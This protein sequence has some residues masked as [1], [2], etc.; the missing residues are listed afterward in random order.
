MT[1]ETSPPTPYYA[2]AAATRPTSVTVLASIGIVLGALGVLCKPAG[3]MINLMVKMPQPNP[4]MD[5]FRNDPAIRA[6][7]IGNAAT[8]TLLSAL[9]LLSSL[10]SLALKPWARMGMLAYGSLAV[11]MTIIGQLVGLFLIGP[12]LESAMRQSGVQ[13]PAG[14]AWM[15]GG[16]G[17][18]LG[19]VIGLWYPALIFIY[20]TRRATR[21]AFDQGLSGTGI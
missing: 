8:G 16:V 3:A 21:E 18:A 12:Q 11:L 5:T 4:I 15:S 20:Y 2:P 14:M 9:L 19:F 7:T 10:G 1:T 17:V 6:F 13:Q